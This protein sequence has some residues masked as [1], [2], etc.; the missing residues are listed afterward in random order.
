MQVSAHIL[1]NKN[2]PEFTL[3]ENLQDDEF[4]CSQSGN[5]ADTLCA[6]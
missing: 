4:V 1:A 3:Q 2:C 6:L 5:L